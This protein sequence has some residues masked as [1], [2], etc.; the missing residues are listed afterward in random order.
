VQDGILMLKAQGDEIQLQQHNAMSQHEYS[1]QYAVIIPAWNEAEYIESSVDSIKSAMSHVPYSGQL[2]VVDNNSTD[3][4]AQL[5]QVAGAQVVFE[6]INQISRARNAGADAA[7]ASIFV[8]VDADSHIDAPLLHA[9]LDAIELNN[10]IGGGAWI[11]GDRKLGLTAWIGINGWNWISRTFKLAAGCFV[12]VRADAFN[13]LGGFTLKRYAG[14]ELTLSR[15]LRRLAKE[16]GM[17]FHII[18]DF[19][20]ETSLRKMD[21]YSSAQLFRQMF[22]ALLPGSMRSRRFMH[23]WYDD[24]TKRTRNGKK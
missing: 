16:R 23:T 12:F 15:S 24:S 14:E 10:N 20:I 22:V 9:A 4:T 11:R 7:E 19:T 13:E 21:W 8:F 2:I 17:G 3:D 18:T 5:A 1:Y 6:P